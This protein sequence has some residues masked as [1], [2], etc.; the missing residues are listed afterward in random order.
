[1]Y[2]VA[3]AWLYV[4]LMMSVAEA[5]NTNGTILGAIVTFLLYGILPTA[6]IVYI[7]GSGHRKKARIAKENEDS[8]AL[9]LQIKDKSDPHP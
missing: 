8:E 2:I 7:M 4:T 5:T 9:K 1:M 6:I 3:I